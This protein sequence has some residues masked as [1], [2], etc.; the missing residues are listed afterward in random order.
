MAAAP[1][2]DLSQP[3]TRKQVRACIDDADESFHACW[4]TLVSL[5]KVEGLDGRALLDFQPV[6]ASALFKL[7]DAYRR[8][9]HYR[10]V[11]IQK[12]ASHS[13]TRF[14]QRMRALDEDRKAL[15]AAMCVGRNLGDAFAWAFYQHDQPSLELHFKNP[16]NP[17]TP[18]GI[19]GR[20][21][22]EFIKQAT[23]R[24][25]FMLYHGIT[26]FLRIGDVSFFD[27]GTRRISAIG[28]FKSELVEP[29]KLMVKV[30]MI[31][32]NREKI[33]FVDPNRAA[34]K[35]VNR[36]QGL[37]REA[38]FKARLERQ[39]KKMAEVV[40][41]SE[42][43]RKADLRS[44]YH[45]DELAIFAKQLS[46][47]GLAFQRVGNGGLLAGCCPF[48]GRSLSSR[49]YSKASQASI[50]KRMARIRER[51]SIICDP[52][53]PDN[54]ILL[55]E[56][57]HG[58][59]L[60]IPPLFWFPCDADFLEKIYFI[61]AIVAT[62][63]NPAHL[64]GALRERGYEVRTEYPKSGT[65]RFEVRKTVSKNMAGIERFDFFLGLIQHRFMRE[66][67]IIEMFDTLLKQVP[68]LG[69]GQAARLELSFVHFL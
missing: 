53:L 36:D 58:L 9:V 24:G 3:P 39:I 61:R 42:P 32:I 64:F 52:A 10:G 69:S 18:P 25:F 4:Q 66:T 31:S 44:A 13:A 27:P 65:P 20:G 57:D 63:Y 37:V 48:R 22:I 29:R 23:P 59:R 14:R 5:K 15:H 62:I 33:P 11:L 30:H 60:G 47:K 26:N 2:K 1:R 67:K 34:K 55:S 12:K 7:D 19:G 50:L 35:T 40:R 54:C 45:T 16:A 56:L 38:Q 41:R 28:E 46:V 21:E 43:D 51:V 68:E 49:I 17:H 6:L 8:L